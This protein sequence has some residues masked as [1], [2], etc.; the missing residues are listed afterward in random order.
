MMKALL[1]RGAVAR[2]Q[3]L[4]AGLIAGLVSTL[5]ACA[6]VPGTSGFDM[7]KESSLALPVAGQDKA[8]GEQGPANVTVT[9]I[10]A[11]LIIAQV[12]ALE[13]SFRSTGAGGR[14]AARPSTVPDFGLMHQ[15]Y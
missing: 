12:R 5:S 7:R 10:T 2:K 1:W 6:L 8:L 13:S 3:L 15:D 11:D 9:P 14:T 4:K